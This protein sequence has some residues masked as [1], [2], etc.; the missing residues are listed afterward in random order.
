MFNTNLKRFNLFNILSF[1]FFG[2]CAYYLGLSVQAESFTAFLVS[3]VAFLLCIIFSI[4]ENKYFNRTYQLK[5]N[6]KKEFVKQNKIK[7]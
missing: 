1:W 4:F 5:K 7:G 6:A 2:N 3:L